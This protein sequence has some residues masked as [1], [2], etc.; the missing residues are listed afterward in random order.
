MER[1]TSV[2]NHIIRYQTI[3]RGFQDDPGGLPGDAGA[4]LQLI[5]WPIG[6]SSVHVPRLRIQACIFFGDGRLHT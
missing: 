5:M 6:L 3:V 2:R 4:V 1:K